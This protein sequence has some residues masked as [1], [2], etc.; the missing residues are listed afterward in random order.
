MGRESARQKYIGQKVSPDRAKNGPKHENRDRGC[1][2]T[3]AGSGGTEL[4]RV[5]ELDGN[6]WNW[7]RTDWSRCRMGQ[8]SGSG[9]V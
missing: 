4:D 7:T 3:T 9:T 5:L 1:P 6:S 8:V 2:S